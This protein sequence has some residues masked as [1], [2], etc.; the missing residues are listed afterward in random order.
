MKRKSSWLI[1]SLTDTAVLGACKAMSEYAPDVD[2]LPYVIGIAVVLVGL[3]VSIGL[4]EIGHLVPAKLFGV[5]VGKYMIGFGPT[6]VSWKK[7][8]TEYGFKALP[9]GGYI[10]MAGMYPDPSPKASAVVTSG[11][12]ETAVTN[13]AVEP[14]SGF[15]SAMVQDA[16]DANEESK[17][18]AGNRTFAAL[19]IYKRIIIMLG[20]PLMNLV[21]AIF[22]FTLLFSGIGVQT[23]STTIQSVS[24]C[25]KPATSTSTV[26]EPGDADAPA[27][28]AG[29]LPGDKIVSI[30]GQ[31][32]TTFD[33]VSDIVRAA[34]DQQLEVVVS[35]DGADQVLILTPMLAERP[36]DDAAGNPR[37]NA[38]GTP[39]IEQVG[40]V[41]FSPTY[42]FMRQGPS[43]GVTAAADNV[44][45]VAEIMI[46]LPAR[47]YDTAVALFTGSDRD[48]NGPLSVVGVGI[49]TGDVV[50]LDAPIMSRVSIVIGL[51]ASLN[52]A[53]FIFNLIPLLPLDGGHIAV[54]LFDGVRRLVAKIMGKPEPRPVDSAKLVPITFV[55]VIL[56]VVMGGIL[57]AADIFNPI[58]LF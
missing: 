22:L 5:R 10:S 34:P 41:G 43:A 31:N 50:A 25:V 1:N 51:L 40:F 45:A 7:G 2:V 57:I 35:R 49:L 48:P 12:Q 20:G 42:E 26:C 19:P 44:T 52:I 13:E 8:E 30:D 47:V 9:I 16:R 33:Q 56:L 29:I 24:E 32:V 3:A 36:V 15:F 27:A 17:E 21:L 18:G 14:R 46:H 39:V 23:A 55:V 53:L 4:H 28:A 6:L 54:A 38:D 11:E 37:V 58:K